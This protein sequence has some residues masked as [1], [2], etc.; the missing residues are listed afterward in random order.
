MQFKTLALL[1][2]A[3]G[4]SVH[5]SAQSKNGTVRMSVPTTDYVYQYVP[6]QPRPT[7]TDVATN[8][9]GASNRIDPQD[10]AAHQPVDRQVQGR[11]VT[12]VLTHRVAASPAD[13]QFVH[14]GYVPC[15]MGAGVLIEADHYAAGLF[16][17]QHGQSTYMMHQVTT[18]SGAV[19]LEDDDQSI[20]WLQLANKS[21]L[22]DHAAG[23]RLS[24]DC[25][26]GEQVVQAQILRSNPSM[27]LLNGLQ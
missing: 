11:A 19:R 13:G 4:I 8:Y 3:A 25:A 27:G 17:M 10:M 24:D 9:T 18:S 20:V 2:V 21:M 1:L 15:A 6:P 7:N 5:A 23:T 16:K 26:N 12:P 22:L 14:T